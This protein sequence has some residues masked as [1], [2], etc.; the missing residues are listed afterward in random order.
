METAEKVLIGTTLFLGAVAIFGPLIVEPLRRWF[1]GS[2]IK[3]IYRH[4][5]PLARKS[6]RRLLKTSK[7]IGKFFD[8]HIRIENSSR[9]QQAQ[10]VE[11]VLEAIWIFDA[12]NKPIPVE[13]FLSVRLRYDSRGTEF[14]DINPHR[15][16]IWNLGFL[17]SPKVQQKFKGLQHFIDVPGANERELAFYLDVGDFPFYQPNRFVPGKYGVKISIYSE[18][19]K[20]V[21]QCFIVDWSGN[22]RKT[23]AEMF[24]EIVITPVDSVN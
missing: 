10:K 24:K 12:S 3:V 13:D 16:I 20:R 11:A 1:Y 19:S 18:N 9:W 17:L 15:H 8:F 21:D 6:A 4:E 22:W 14:V 5:P 2:K 23:E 7:R